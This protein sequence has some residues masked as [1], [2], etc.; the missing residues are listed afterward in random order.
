MDSIISDDLN[1]SNTGVPKYEYTALD[2]DAKAFAKIDK[3]EKEEGISESDYQ[4]P[5][6]KWGD[7]GKT[8]NSPVIIQKFYNI[9]HTFY[10]TVPDDHL[11]AQLA[12]FYNSKV[13]YPLSKINLN[14]NIQAITGAQ[15]RHHLTKCDSSNKLMHVWEDIEYIRRAQH[16]LRKKG[17]FV[18]T[19]DGT[20]KLDPTHTRYFL[21][22]SKH[23]MTLLKYADELE[24]KRRKIQKNLKSD[25]INKS[26]K[27]NLKG[28]L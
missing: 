6:C 26:R 19:P 22:M 20:K 5:L 25:S 12:T 21:E 16:Q 17:N 8:E 7:G 15:V 11:Y 2:E 3:E 1:D 27:S 18:Q 13:Y 23:K 28:L 9:Y 4:C 10:R 24:E 14:G